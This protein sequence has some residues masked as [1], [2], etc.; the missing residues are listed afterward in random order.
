MVYNMLLWT[1]HFWISYTK[2][3]KFYNDNLSDAL[4]SKQGGTLKLVNPKHEDLA[5]VQLLTVS[6]SDKVWGLL[7]SL[8]L[9]CNVIH[10]QWILPSKHW[11]KV[12]FANYDE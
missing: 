4:G 5:S 8:L 9:S 1:D 3:Y 10:L 7:F 11:K 6:I 2:L 12:I